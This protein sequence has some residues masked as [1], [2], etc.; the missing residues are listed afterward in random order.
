MAGK[1]LCKNFE[2]GMKEE[3]LF[4]SNANM[5]IQ[6]QDLHMHKKEN[7]YHFGTRSNSDM[8]HEHLLGP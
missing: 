5:I 7:P 3:N 8:N 2:G 4:I 1:E 6:E